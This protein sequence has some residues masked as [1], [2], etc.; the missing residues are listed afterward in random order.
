[1]APPVTRD[2]LA[3]AP[4]WPERYLTALSGRRGSRA[5][6]VSIFVLGGPLLGV[7]A[8]REAVRYERER[9]ATRFGQQLNERARL[10]Q[11]D[12]HSLAEELYRIRSLFAIQDVVSRAGFRV[13]TERALSMRPELRAFEWA[14]RVTDDRREAHERTVRREGATGYRIFV[15]GPGG[16]RTPAPRRSEYFPI[17]YAE[18]RA[19]NERAIGF[20]LSSEPTRRAALARARETQGLAVTDPIDLVQEARPSKALL[21]LLPVLGTSATSGRSDPLQGFLLLVVGVPELL[22]EPLPPS[23]ANGA[24]RLRYQLVDE[25]TGEG[26]T[27]IAASPDWL[28]SSADGETTWVR[29]IGIGDRRWALAGRP[30]E[31][32]HSERPDLNRHFLGLIDI[33]I[34]GN[35]PG[36]FSSQGKGDAAADTTRC[37]GNNGNFILWHMR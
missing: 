21:V 17:L 15:P 22:A 36:S 28:T 8:Y 2:G 19:T 33:E 7:L 13:F 27:V 29:G 24:A 34:D 12:L 9:A 1:M 4:G 14:P 5:V 32:F 6:V 3:M 18:P 37:S 31:R 20:D 11:R 35:D 26:E 10:L 23:E 16:S 25:G 30:T